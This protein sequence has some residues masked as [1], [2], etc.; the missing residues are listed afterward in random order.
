MIEKSITK[1]GVKL[2][3]RTTAG[4]VENLE[5]LQA[6]SEGVEVTF[7]ANIFWLLKLFHSVSRAP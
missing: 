7:V 1:E 4:S 6:D 2:N 3:I 5:L